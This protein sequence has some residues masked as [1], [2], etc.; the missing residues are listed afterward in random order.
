[1]KQIDNENDKEND[2]EI[3]IEIEKEKEKE[4]ERGRGKRNEKEKEKEKGKEKE[5]NLC[6]N[7]ICHNLEIN[8]KS[9]L[10]VFGTKS[11]LSKELQY[12]EIQQKMELEIGQ[13]IP[14]IKEKLRSLYKNKK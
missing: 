6:F 12:I 10:A 7:I 3:E 4:I 5:A 8:K 13:T 2:I 11:I 14:T 9:K 1:M